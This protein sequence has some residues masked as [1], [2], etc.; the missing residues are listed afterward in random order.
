M[1]GIK[2]E[3]FC[4][5]TVMRDFNNT[6]VNTYVVNKAISSFE[7]IDF[8]LAKHENVPFIP[9]SA[10]VKVAAILNSTDAWTTVPGLDKQNALQEKRS[11]KLQSKQLFISEVLLR[12]DF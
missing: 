1:K 4:I 3:D 8:Y 7:Y 11:K 6:S 12:L 2:F 9:G 10:F 5:L